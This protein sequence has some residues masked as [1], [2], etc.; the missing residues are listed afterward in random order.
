LGKFSKPVLLFGAGG[1]AAD[2][3]DIVVRAWDMPV[4]G[5]VVDRPS[6]EAATKDAP[7]TIQWDDISSR[8]DSFV[9][10][11][12]IGRPERRPF[13]E[14]A[15]AAG[16]HFATLI[17]PSAQIFPSASV[18][19][20]CVIGASCIVAA[21]GRIGRHV[22]LNRGVAIGHHTSIEHFCSVQ[23]GVS[24]GGFCNIEEETEIGIG[25]T[26][27][28][29]ITIGARSFVGAGSVVVKD[30]TTDSKLLGN[31]ARERSK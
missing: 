23:A 7:P 3:A 5:F 4:A 10:V 9:C 22:F 2:I 20:G 25:A 27:I 26:V 11:A 21:H 28:D 6:D 24:V 1:L 18:A 12:A 13:I 31:P 15:E 29:R 19:P 8:A 14:K 16:F 30:C 17:D